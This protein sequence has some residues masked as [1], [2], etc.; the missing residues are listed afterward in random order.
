MR[1][2]DVRTE[3][4]GGAVLFDDGG[5]MVEENDLRQGPAAVGG[6]CAPLVVRQP[7]VDGRVYKLGWSRYL[8]AEHGAEV[9]R[10]VAAADCTG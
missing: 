7:G 6:R 5:L 10:S 2:H 9:V 3:T 8:D 1:R 4:M